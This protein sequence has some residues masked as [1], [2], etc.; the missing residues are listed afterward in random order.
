[1]RLRTEYLADL[2][3][4]E[5]DPALPYMPPASVRQWHEVTQRYRELPPAMLAT[6]RDAY[7]RSLALTKLLADAGVPMLTGTDNGG[8]VPGQSLHQEFDEL[9]KAGLGP[10]KILQMTTLDPARFL[11]RL[12][13]MGSV[14]AGKNADLVLLDADPIASAQNLHRIAGVVRAGQYHSAA[15]LAA[16]K[17]R[18]KAGQGYLAGVKGDKPAQ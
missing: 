13:T 1:M 3:E 11:D 2:P 7:R 18:V 17:A 4:Y 8:G 5:H 9:A 14:A 12:A 15:Q 10:L 6:F 16:L